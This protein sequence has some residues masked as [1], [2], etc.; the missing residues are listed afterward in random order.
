VKETALMH[1]YGRFGALLN[2][3]WEL[4]VVLPAVYVSAPLRRRCFNHFEVHALLK[5]NAA[6][7]ACSVRLL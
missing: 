6:F 5:F 7:E 4:C 1:V 2:N 3:G